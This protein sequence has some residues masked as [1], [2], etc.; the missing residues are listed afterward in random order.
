MYTQRVFLSGT[1]DLGDVLYVK[2]DGYVYAEGMLKGDGIEIP[3]NL[4]SKHYAEIEEKGIANVLCEGIFFPK[5]TD[6]ESSIQLAVQEVYPA[7]D[8]PLNRVIVHGS[9]TNLRKT[10]SA[11]LM[12]LLSEGYGIPIYLNVFCDAG[13][14]REAVSEKD[15]VVVIGRLRNAKDTGE[16][17]I[18]ADEVCPTL[19]HYEFVL[20]AVSGD[21]EEQVWTDEE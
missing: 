17:V 3:V 13:K 11:Y 6:E 21:A 12:E 18:F 16:Y 19:K 15:E 5:H 20:F 7:T 14:L 1:I 9:I 8:A 10:R 2:K 4:K